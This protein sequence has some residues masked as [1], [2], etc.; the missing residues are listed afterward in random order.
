MITCER[1]KLTLHS[2]EGHATAADCLRHLVPRYAAMAEMANRQAEHE[3]RLEGRLERAQIQQKTAEQC[4]RDAQKELKHERERAARLD[5][6]RNVLY[7]GMLTA[8]AEATAEK[9][10]YAKAI[11]RLRKIADEYLVAAA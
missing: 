10:R 1:C 6:A 11:A 5:L 8:Q 7:S 4:R 2:I 9:K 3:T